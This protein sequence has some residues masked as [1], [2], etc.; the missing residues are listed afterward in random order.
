MERGSFDMKLLFHFGGGQGRRQCP[1][2]ELQGGGGGSR[3][4]VK[5]SA[6]AGVASIY[7]QRV[8]ARVNSPRLSLSLA[9]RYIHSHSRL[10]F[11]LSFSLFSLVCHLFLLFSFLLFSLGSLHF[12][13]KKRRGLSKRGKSQSTPP[14]PAFDFGAVPASF[15][16]PIL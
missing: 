7:R 9:S 16:L 15:A 8:R 11:S 1:R 14:V 13:K 2:E 3:G 4:G 10:S 6:L 5:A 12:F